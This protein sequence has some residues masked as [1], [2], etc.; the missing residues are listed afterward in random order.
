MSD[1]IC[2]I[3]GEPATNMSQDTKEIAPVNGFRSWEKAGKPVYGCDEH[4]AREPV[5]Y[6]LHNN[7]D[8]FVMAKNRQ[9]GG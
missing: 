7:P 6:D 3:C 4:P 1:P 5:V 9:I 8:K 2:D